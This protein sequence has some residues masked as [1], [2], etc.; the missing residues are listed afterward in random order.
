MRAGHS[1]RGGYGS[2]SGSDMANRSF[3]WGEAGLYLYPAVDTTHGNVITAGLGLS[4]KTPGRGTTGDCNN[5]NTL[6]FK[7]NANAYGGGDNMD[8]Y[9]FAWIGF[10]PDWSRDLTL[11]NHVVGEHRG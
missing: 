11:E 7:G 1:G 6:D 10:A 5:A 3:A 8:A 2:G 9:G 4:G